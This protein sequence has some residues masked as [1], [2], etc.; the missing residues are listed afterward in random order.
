MLAVLIIKTL[1]YVCILYFKLKKMFNINQLLNDVK[2]CNMFPESG[3]P[4]FQN[5][6]LDLIFICI[7]FYID[8]NECERT[9]GLC[10]GGTC[11]NTPGSFYCQCPP[12]HELSPDKLSCKGSVIKFSCYYF[13]NW[14]FPVNYIQ[15][16]PCLL[17]I[18]Y[19]KCINLKFLIFSN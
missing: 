9:P 5:V 4:Q 19:L 2:L 15:F 3:I 11:R 7:F 10:R 12:G 18:K 16:L 17:L 14:L 13:S 1:L 6:P 8:I